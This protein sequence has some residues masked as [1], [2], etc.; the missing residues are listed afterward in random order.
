MEKESYLE[1]KEYVENIVI[2]RLTAKDSFEYLVNEVFLDW[3]NIKDVEYLCTYVALGLFELEHNALED[4]VECEM[5]GWIK[6][7]KE[8]K[9]DGLIS[10]TKLLDEDINK[11]ESMITLRFDEVERID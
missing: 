6:E 11:I 3:F 4:E 2:G 8:G 9:F 1:N 5:T 7:Y 10:D